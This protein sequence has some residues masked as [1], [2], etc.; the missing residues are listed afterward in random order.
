MNEQTSECE[1]TSGEMCS[2]SHL[3]GVV[4]AEADDAAAE[5]LGAAALLDVDV[6][7]DMEDVAVVEL[8]DDNVVDAA[9]EVLN[10]VIVSRETVGFFNLPSFTYNQ[11]NK[12]IDHSGVASALPLGFVD[13]AGIRTPPPK[14]KMPNVNTRASSTPTQNIHTTENYFFLWSKAFWKVIETCPDALAASNCTNSQFVDQNK[15]QF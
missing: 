2:I 4:G 13:L 1:S 10:A 12:I 14:K 8:V 15:R 7:E 5:L 9:E 3:L 6:A 11:P